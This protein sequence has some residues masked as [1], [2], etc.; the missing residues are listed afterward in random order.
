MT[1]AASPR[2]RRP[3]NSLTE[4]EILD[5]AESV[6]A[7]GFAAL[8]MRAV[9][10]ELGASPMALYRYFAT[11]DELVDALLDRV[12]G[13][14]EFADEV[15]T[16][17]SGAPGDP[18]AELDDFAHRHLAL[19]LAHPWAVAPLVAHPLPG[20]N[21]F[22]IGEHALAILERAGLAGDD[23]VALFSGILALNYGWASFAISRSEPDAASSMARLF[24]TTAPGLPRTAAVAAEMQRYGSD[25]HYDRVIA[26]LLDSV[27]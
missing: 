3:R 21:A 24:A 18:R 7:N 14:I 10:D 27:G 11:K 26:R 8:T 23:A 25:D 22:P 2:T 15:D 4:H 20:P 5:A 12:L 16:S 17:E 1:D 13:R 9:A 19:L 6:A